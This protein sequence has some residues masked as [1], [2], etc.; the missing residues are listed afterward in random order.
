MNVA[1]GFGFS[2]ALQCESDVCDRKTVFC[3][4]KTMFRKT[5]QVNNM[6]SNWETVFPSDPTGELKQKAGKQCGPAPEGL[7]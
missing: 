1:S 6:F 2:I 7:R 4:V 5:P 3:N